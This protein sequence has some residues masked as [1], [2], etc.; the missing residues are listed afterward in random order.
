MNDNRLIIIGDV[1]GRTFWRDAVR[2]NPDGRFIFLGDFLDP[3]PDEGY[4]DEEVFKGLEDIIQFKKDNPDRVILLW[5]N[6]DLHYLYPEYM[7]SRYDFDHAERNA[8]MFWDNQSL[9]QM[10]Y[11]VNAGGKHFLFSHAGI[12]RQWISSNFPKLDDGDITAELM[13]NLVGYP[14]FM[15]ALE[16]VSLFR[17]GDK[18]Y[19]SMIWADPRD[20]IKEENHLHGVIQVFGHTQM[21]MPF[22]Y[23]DKVYCL[24]CRQ[25]FYLDLDAGGIYYLRGNERIGRSRI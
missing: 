23:D 25:A 16:D 10:A 7:G 21:D 1:H 2:R 14:E 13:N 22:N 9:F 18:K 6:H 19:G 15:K 8:H 12:G 3:Y 24:D 20:I 5:E 4:I 11:E 17:G